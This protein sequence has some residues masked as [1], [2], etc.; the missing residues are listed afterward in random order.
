MLLMASERGLQGYPRSGAGLESTYGFNARGLAG[1]GGTGVVWV[2]NGNAPEYIRKH[3]ALQGVDLSKAGN[4]ERR[5]L[6][7][8]RCSECRC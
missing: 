8:S 1:F 6:S 5:F 4:P 2:P 7:P 3:P